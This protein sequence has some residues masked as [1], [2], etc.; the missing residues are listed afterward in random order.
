[1]KFWSMSTLLMKILSHFRDI[2]N[3]ILQ[4][5]KDISSDVFSTTAN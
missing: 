1:M 3:K 4:K 2:K 5:I